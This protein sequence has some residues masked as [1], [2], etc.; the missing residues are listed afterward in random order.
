MKI[1]VCL[2]DKGGM[3]FNKRRQSRDR[4]LLQ[5]LAD[6]V[7]DGAIFVNGFSAPLFE[8]STASVIEV[9]DPLLSAGDGDFVF[10]EN[11]SLKRARDK[12]EEMIIYRWNR[13]YPADFF[14]DLEP[15]EAGL[16][17]VESTEFSG[18]SHEK[19]TREIYR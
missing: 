2:C 16:R 1:I 11:L 17:L 5:N 10:L 6:Y 15:S 19:I 4:V 13:S 18:S 12:I 9:S 7:N 3:L 8:S 14:L